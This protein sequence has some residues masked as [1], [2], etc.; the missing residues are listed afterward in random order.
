MP[1]NPL[2][3]KDAM[4]GLHPGFAPLSSMWR[5]K[6][7]AVVHAVGLPQPNRS[8]SS[9][10]E[11]IEDADLGSAARVGWINRLVGLDSTRAALRAVGI[12]DGV[13]PSSLYGPQPALAVESVD[14]VTLSGA[15]QKADTR[16]ARRRALSQVWSHSNSPFA[17]GA[18]ASLTTT[19]TLADTLAHSNRP[20]NGARYPVGSLGDALKDTAR[21]I[22]ARVGVEVVTLDHGTWDMHSH[23]GNLSVGGNSSMR[24]MVGTLARGLAAFFN[25]LGVAGNRVTVVTVTEFGRRVKEN[26][27][28]GLD[29]GWA[30]ATLVPGGGVGG[31]DYYGRDWPGLADAA[32][33]DGD[34]IVTTDYR[35]IIS[36]IIFKRFQ[37]NIVEGLP[38]LSGPRTSA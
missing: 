2:L 16:R 1:K 36:E 19:A 30:N 8:H 6:K 21:L 7:F 31:G 27:S 12:G 22:K 20:A 25:G 33:E 17:V 34:L 38:G 15:A 18:R 32:L 3:F 26:G 37:P 9:A 29:H 10:I 5:N 28:A 24:G 35:S 4:F 14:D 23:L 11:E 13:V